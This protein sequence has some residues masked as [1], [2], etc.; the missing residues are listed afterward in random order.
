MLISGPCFARVI[1]LNEV[2]IARVVLKSTTMDVTS[3]RAIHTKRCIVYR[4]VDEYCDMEYSLKPKTSKYPLRMSQVIYLIESN[5]LIDEPRDF[6]YDNGSYGLPE[7]VYDFATV[8]SPYLMKIASLQEGGY[9]KTGSVI[10]GLNSD[11]RW[12]SLN[13]DTFSCH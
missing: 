5:N 10:G 9:E 3:I 4:I 1:Y 13:L 7:E 12:R 6:N 11:Q 2:E 8:S